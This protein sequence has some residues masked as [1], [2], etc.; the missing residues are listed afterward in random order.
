MAPHPSPARNRVTPLGDIVATPLR[1]AWTGNRGRLHE[2]REI[3]R[4]HSG[5]LWITCALRFK[6]RWDEQWRPH[7]FTWLFFGDEAIALAAGH[8]P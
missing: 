6:D 2:G 3:V 4:F 8:R 1:G 5:D 7:R